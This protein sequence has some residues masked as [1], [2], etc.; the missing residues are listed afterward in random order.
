[1][2]TM[3]KGPVDQYELE[4]DVKRWTLA[5]KG[6]WDETRYELP[7]PTPLSSAQRKALEPALDAMQVV[8]DSPEACQKKNDD[9]TIYCGTSTSIAIDGRVYSGDD[10]SCEYV[11]YPPDADPHQAVGRTFRA[12][13]RGSTTATPPSRAQDANTR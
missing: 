8:T 5:G 4:L 10:K 13:A 6:T 1:M 9:P 2:T 11:D 12:L 7:E 3:G